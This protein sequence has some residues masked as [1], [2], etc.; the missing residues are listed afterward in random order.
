MRSRQTKRRVRKR[1]IEA[2]RIG[3]K[4]EVRVRRGVNEANVIEC[5]SKIEVG[6]RRCGEGE[7]NYTSKEEE[8]ED[9]L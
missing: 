1:L 6:G 4:I 9:L 3:R 5:W 2:V 8:V 7:E